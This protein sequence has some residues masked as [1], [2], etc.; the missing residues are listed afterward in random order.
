M[1]TPN[2]P[3]EEKK[4]NFFSKIFKP[5][6][7]SL[8]LK[9][10]FVQQLGIML[11]AGIAVS[12]ALRTLSE[13]TESKALKAILKD[14]EKVIEKGSTLSKGLE[15][16]Q[17]VFGDLFINMIAAGEASGKLEEV[18][19]ELFVQMKKDHEIISKV[20]GA[21]IYPVI[22][23][24]LM[25]G[26]GVMMSIY[27]IPAMTSVF[28]EMNVDLPLPTKVLM[29]VSDFLL[30]NGVYV[31]I[32]TIILIISFQR[33]ISTQKGK[34]IFHKIL[35]RTPIVG[36]IIKQINLARFCRT[37]SSLL[38]TD[39]PIVQS[40]EITARVLGN[41]NYKKALFEAQDKIK[42]GVSIKESLSSYPNLFPP[43]VLQ[44]ITVGEET[45]ELDN[46]LQESAIFYE[47]AVNQTM[48]N[49]PSILEPV[50]MVILGLAVGAMAVAVMLPMY[51]LGQ[52]I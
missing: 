49:L 1:P 9:I 25:L 13:Q 48:T 12:L 30:A 28:K 7:I 34:F 31:L 50:L 15:Q 35:I 45:G 41:V 14:L 27:V 19:G 21:M 26:I 47:E 42:K 11:K 10:F 4:P 5:K 51:S 44:M 18:L 29:F 33:V 32:G 39:I 17:K 37:I 6:K 2:N 3:P 16:Y 46:I 20:R 22:V 36:A 43:V 24:L 8:S 23:I 38:K 52:A 40:F